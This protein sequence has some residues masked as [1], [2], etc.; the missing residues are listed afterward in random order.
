M[1]EKDDRSLLAYWDDSGVQTIGDVLQDHY[2]N[3]RNQQVW[4]AAK[5]DGYRYVWDRRPGNKRV[6]VSS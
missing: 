2:N 5:Y 1:L 3:D 4:T 6:S